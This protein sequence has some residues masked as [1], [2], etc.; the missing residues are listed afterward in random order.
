M[1]FILVFFR[2]KGD[3]NR[4]RPRACEGAQVG[5]ARDNEAAFVKGATGGDEQG[6]DG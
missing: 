3:A 4:P 2:S 6:G 1:V 5:S